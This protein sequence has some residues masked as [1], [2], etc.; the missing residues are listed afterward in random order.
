MRD[1][2]S[3]H[4]PQYVQALNERQYSDAWEYRA[5]ARRNL[6]QYEVPPGEVREPYNIWHEIAD[7][8]DL[9]PGERLVDHGTAEGD[10]YR[11]IRS[12]GYSP[13]FIGVDIEAGHS[14]GL[15]RWIRSEYSDADF[16]LVEG[17]SQNLA[18]IFPDNYTGKQ[19]A[20][21]LAYH[22]PRPSR[23]LSEIHRLGEPGSL[24]VLSTRGIENQRDIWE[25]ARLVA[26]NNGSAFKQEFDERT[27]RFI[28]GKS[29]DS[30]SFYSHFSIEQM[31]QSLNQ[32]K[33][34][35]IV[36][37]RGD[38]QKSPLWIPTSE[39]GWFD[40]SWAV[41]SLLANMVNLKTGHPPEEKELNAM[42]DWLEVHMRPHFINQG[43][44]NQNAMG[45]PG[46]YY[47][48]Q[49]RQGYFVVEIVK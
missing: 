25:T 47:I 33:K 20:N 19:T 10:F 5:V 36:K 41:Q 30:I 12:R 11:I 7:E 39:S 4:R 1:R 17:D 46:P 43:L 27:L 3:P 21:F 35:N 8:L 48:S 45:L 37:D 34:F 2:Y 29:I 6:Y 23:L 38:A 18:S 26:H 31:R 28:N 14:D 9:V 44:Y 40:L 16:R 42:S 32:S 22:V 13:E 49:V 15:E 24:A